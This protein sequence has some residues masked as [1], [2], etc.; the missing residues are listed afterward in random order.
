M[1]YSDDNHSTRSRQNIELPGISAR[2]VSMTIPL[3][4][5]YEREEAFMSHTGPLYSHKT[6]QFSPMSGPLHGSQTPGHTSL[7]KYERHNSKSHA[8]M[9]EEMHERYWLDGR[10]AQS[11]E[12]L[13]MSGPLAVCNNADCIDC[14]AAYKTRRGYYRASGSL[15]TKVLWF[16]R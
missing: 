11:N 9:P 7:V 5:S 12:H 15:E 1:A 14:P 2:S 16:N 4:A 3:N 6:S 8:V 10:D 13:W